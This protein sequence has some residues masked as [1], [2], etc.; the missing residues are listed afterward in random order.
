MKFDSSDIITILQKFNKVEG[1]IFPRDIKSIQ[2]LKPHDKN[3]LITFI[4]K[5]KKYAILIDNSAEDD[6]EY[7]YSQI[8]SHISGSD[9]YQL[10]YL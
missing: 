4:F 3:V 10:V 5:G 7:I 6:D 2:K 1:D 9:N 8:T